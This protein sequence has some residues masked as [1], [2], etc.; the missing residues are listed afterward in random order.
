MCQAL[1]K[2]VSR[3]QNKI[4]P[5]LSEFTFQWADETDNKQDKHIKYVVF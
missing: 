5:I 2:A 1:F 3:E 4:I